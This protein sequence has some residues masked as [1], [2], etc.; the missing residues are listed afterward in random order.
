VT[1]T[2][3]YHKVVSV[4]INWKFCKLVP[5]LIHNMCIIV[6]STSAKKFGFKVPSDYSN[7]DET[8]DGTL[9]VAPSI[10]VFL[11]SLYTKSDVGNLL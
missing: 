11:Y 4:L 10:T 2:N 9:F 7:N 6:G 8:L 5:A 1:L 3:T